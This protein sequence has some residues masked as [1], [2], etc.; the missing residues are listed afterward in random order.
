MK[1][2]PYTRIFVKFFSV[3][4][5]IGLIALSIVFACTVLG[6]FG[7]ISD[8]DI[9]SLTMDSSSQVFYID[10]EGNQKPLTTLSSESGLISRTFR[11]T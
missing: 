5:G 1:N 6:F 7:G 4:I 8:L 9:N 3:T 10:A 11:R 2:N